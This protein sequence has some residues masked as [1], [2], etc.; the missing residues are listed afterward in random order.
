MY[1]MFG[2]P[3]VLLVIFIYEGID[4]GLPIMVGIG[5]LGMGLLFLYCSGKA[6]GKL[7]YL[8]VVP[9]S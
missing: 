6:A 7:R 9:F 1:G 2:S 5:V 3:L 8:N 4:L